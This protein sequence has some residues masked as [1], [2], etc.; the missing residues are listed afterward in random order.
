ME[1][2]VVHFSFAA[3]GNPRRD[4]ELRLKTTNQ[5]RDNEDLDLWLHGI[6]REL[7]LEH[8]KLDKLD[9]VSGQDDYVHLYTT[10]RSFPAIT[11]D[12]D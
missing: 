7:H 12:D 9:S 4:L 3:L 8:L 11:G 10:D 2:S 6:L 5:K 1:S